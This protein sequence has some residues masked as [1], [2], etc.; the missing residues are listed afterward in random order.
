[1]TSSNITQLTLSPAQLAPAAVAPLIKSS[2]GVTMNDL[3]LSPEAGGQV[4]ITPT[5][6]A[7]SDPNWRY[8]GHVIATFAQCDLGNVFGD[9][10]LRLCIPQVPA[11]SGDVADMLA[12]IFDVLLVPADVVDVLLPPVLGGGTTFV[13]QASPN[14]SMWKGQRTVILFPTTIETTDLEELVLNTDL[15][16]LIPPLADGTLAE[17]AT[18]TVMPGLTLGQLNGHATHLEDFVQKP[19]V[20][21]LTLTQ[22][23]GQGHQ[24]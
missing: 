12:Q 3:V 10:E 4:V 14:S 1:M 8:Y 6:A 22:L 17:L 20:P 2:S 11:R 7:Y 21:G 24:L 18:D 16:G 9:F 5:Q 15:P 13:L 19:N 23:S